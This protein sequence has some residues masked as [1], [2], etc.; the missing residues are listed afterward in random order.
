MMMQDRI[1]EVLAHAGLPIVPRAVVEEL[2][3]VVVAAT[4]S[5][6]EVFRQQLRLKCVEIVY[7][8]GAQTHRMDL[9]AEAERL[10]QFVVKAAEKTA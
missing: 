5:P 9:E 7:T 3:A 1:N 10:Y 4:G 6:S 2:C 8:V